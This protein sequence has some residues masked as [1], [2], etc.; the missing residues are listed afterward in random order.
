MLRLGL[1]F[2]EAADLARLVKINDG[3]AVECADGAVVVAFKKPL[4]RHGASLLQHSPDAPLKHRPLLV[5][6]GKPAQDLLQPVVLRAV[7]LRVDRVL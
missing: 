7:A 3:Y 5:P 1:E 2:A 6:V 4:D